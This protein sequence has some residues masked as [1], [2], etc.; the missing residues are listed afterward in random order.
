[1][2]LEAAV[3]LNSRA[4]AH[5]EPTQLKLALSPEDAVASTRTGTGDR[6]VGA[7]LNVVQV[8]VAW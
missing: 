7:Y 4:P 5:E 8:T 2:S 6:T 3:Q 1:M